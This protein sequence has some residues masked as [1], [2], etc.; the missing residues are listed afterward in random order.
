MPVL[1]L[2]AAGDLV[3]KQR[4][5]VIFPELQGARPKGRNGLK[6]ILP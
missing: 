2:E 5:P 6:G 3:N 1:Q 4:L